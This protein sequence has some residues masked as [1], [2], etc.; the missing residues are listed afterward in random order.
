MADIDWRYELALALR[1]IR[2][3]VETL[4]PVAKQIAEDVEERSKQ[5]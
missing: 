1:A 3:L 5:K 4:I 2:K